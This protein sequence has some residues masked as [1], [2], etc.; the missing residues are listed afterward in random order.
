MKNPVACG[1]LLPL[2]S[3]L[4]ARPESIG[5]FGGSA[6]VVQVDTHRPGVILAAT[7]RLRRISSARLAVATRRLPGLDDV[8]AAMDADDS[9]Y[10]VA[11][12]DTTA[13]GRSLG[14]GIVEFGDHLTAPDPVAEPGGLEYR[15]GPARRAPAVPFC[16]LAGWSARAF[17]RLWYAKA[18]ARSEATVPLPDFFHRLDAVSDWNRALGRRGILQYQF[19][20]PDAGQAVLAEVLE[21][22]AGSRP[23]LGTL[24]RFGPASAAPL[25]F[26][27][28]GW[29][30]AIDL[31]AGNPRLGLLLDDLDRRVA[32]A[33][34]RV[35]LAKDARLTRPAFARMYAGLPAWRPVRDRLDP[36]GV[37]QSDQGRRVG[38]C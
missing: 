22:L 27:L 34:G 35:Y 13:T 31:P 7:L 19:A 33:S 12:I 21:R 30:L 3:L 25:S 20:V 28:A 29:S 38:L 6:A 18:P 37:F 2:C 8:L 36:A 9:R 17:N 14:R 26:P 23:F 5:P 11:W 15:A 16:P 1:V 4:A 32:D 24:K 10:A